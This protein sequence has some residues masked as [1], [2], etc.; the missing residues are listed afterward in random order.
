M[1]ATNTA[2][3][4]NGKGVTTPSEFFFFTKVGFHRKQPIF[5]TEDIT[6]VCN[7]ID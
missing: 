7:R 6:A 2:F 3:R 5:I 1:S 4:V